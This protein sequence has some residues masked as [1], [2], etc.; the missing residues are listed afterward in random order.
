MLKDTFQF[1]IDIF[2]WG[3][4]NIYIY[5]VHTLLGCEDTQQWCFY[6]NRAFAT[7]P[8]TL[9]VRDAEIVGQQTVM[10]SCM[11]KRCPGQMGLE[12]GV[13][14]ITRENLHVSIHFFAFKAE[15]TFMIWKD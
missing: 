13:V 15:E 9:S 14:L 5:S 4:K 10:M 2:R 8:E 7:H 1:D 12:T 3:L 11:D 6:T